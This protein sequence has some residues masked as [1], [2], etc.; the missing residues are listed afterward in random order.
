MAKARK[1]RA[2]LINAKY[3]KEAQSVLLWLECEHGKFRSQ[4]HRDQIATFG[5][6]TEEEIEHEMNKYVETLKTIYGGKLINAVF[7]PSLQGT[8]D[9]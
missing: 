8:N 9:K 7:D 3:I 5:T 6:R 2:T 1:I 4:I